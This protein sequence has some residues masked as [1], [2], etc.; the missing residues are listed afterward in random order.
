MNKKLKVTFKVLDNVACKHCGTKIYVEKN[1]K[2]RTEQWKRQ[3][4]FFCC[5]FYISF[6]LSFLSE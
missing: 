3:F 6:S 1:L 2:W 4:G 5:F